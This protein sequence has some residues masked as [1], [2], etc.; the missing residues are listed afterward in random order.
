MIHEAR[1]LKTTFSIYASA[2]L[3]YLS[4]AASFQDGTGLGS[5]ITNV[6]FFNPV[7]VVTNWVYVGPA[8]VNKVC[9]NQNGVTAIN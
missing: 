6:R 1:H 2:P 9:I 8:E 5:S 3:P 4:P 7:R